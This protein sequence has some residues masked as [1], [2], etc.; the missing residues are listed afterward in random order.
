MEISPLRAQSKAEKDEGWVLGGQTEECAYLF[1]DV[2][3]VPVCLP[4]A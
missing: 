2:F 4:G 1:I 3:P